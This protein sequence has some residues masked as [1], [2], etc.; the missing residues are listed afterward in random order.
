[1]LQWSTE[2]HGYRLDLAAVADPSIHAGIPGAR[3]LVGLVDANLGDDESLQ[4]QARHETIDELGSE[5]F[6]DAAAVIGNFEMMNR[7]AEGT[8]IPI[9]PQAL[10]R[11]AEMMRTLGLYDILKSHQR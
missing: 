3:A 2:T 5:G 4:D 10:E 6:V 7:V 11:E 8:G 1:M 9:A